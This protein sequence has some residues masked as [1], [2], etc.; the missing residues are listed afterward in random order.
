[1]LLSTTTSDLS[2]SMESRSRISAARAGSS[3]PMASAASRSQ[4]PANTESRS[5]NPRSC[6]SSNSS[7]HCR[8]AL[9]VWWRGGAVRLPVVSRLKGFSSRSEICSTV[10]ALTLAAAS[11]ITS[12]MPSK[13]RHNLA[14]TGAFRSVSAKFAL[15]C[16]ARSTKSRSAS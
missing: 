6:S 5:N 16:L 10:N 4:P 2:I 1:M 11:S 3:A 13:L 8:A 12:G 9:S 7:L 14:T 15:A